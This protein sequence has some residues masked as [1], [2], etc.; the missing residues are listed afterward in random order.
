MGASML[1]KDEASGLLR[2]TGTLVRYAVPPNRREFFLADLE[3]DPL[4]FVHDPSCECPA[5]AVRVAEDQYEAPWTLKLTGFQ[6]VKG[7]DLEQAFIS[8]DA[9][10]AAGVTL[11][12]KAYR[13]RDNKGKR[14][15]LSHARRAMLSVG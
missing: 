14:V 9:A 7:S 6:G 5:D 12:G 2:D 4:V 11:R 3:S 13:L 8:C 15:Y 1:G 10:R